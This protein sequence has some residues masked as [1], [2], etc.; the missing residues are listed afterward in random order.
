[1]IGNKP[2]SELETE[3]A[4]FTGTENHYQHC[5][6]FHYTDGIKYLAERAGAYWLLDLIG[7][8]QYKCKNVGFQI[9][10]LDVDND[11]RGV[12]TMRED[13]GLPDLVTQ[14]IPYTDFPIGKLELY[15]I[16]DVLLLKTEY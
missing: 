4:N 14:R 11:K 13:D 3:L 9:W 7:S 1:M 5:F 12:V 8:Y 10:R 2:I 6:G 16:D 15:Y